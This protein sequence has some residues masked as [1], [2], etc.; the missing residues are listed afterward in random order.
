[1]PRERKK[2]RSA[3]SVK[4]AEPRILGF[5]REHLILLAIFLFAVFVRIQ[6]DPNIPYHYDPGKNIVYARAALQSF[7]LF[8]Q[9]NPYFNLGEYF[10]YQVLFPYTVAFLNLLTGISLVDSTKWLVIL[11][12]SA[13]CLTVYYLSLELFHDETAALVSAFVIAASKIQLLAYMNYYP[14]ILAMMFMPL[15]F[16]FLIRYVRSGNARDLV[17]V[18]LLSS[19]IVLASY[20]AAFVYFLIVAVSLALWAVKDT[21]TIKTLL[22]VPAMTMALLTFFWLPIAWRLGSL[23]F[24]GIAK[25][26]LFTATSSPFTNEPWTLV[27]YLSVSGITVVTVIMGL[28]AL[29]LIRKIQWDFG[30]LLLAVWLTCVFF[31]MESY[32]VR[33]ILWVDR[34]AQFLDIAVLLLTG[35]LFSLFISKMNTEKTMNSPVGGY[36]LLLLLLLPLYG[37]VHVDTIYGK[38]GYP[39]DFAA[40]EYMK[41]LPPGT[42]VVAPPSVQSFWVSALSGAHVLGGE[43]AQMIYPMYRGDGDSNTIINSA[44]VERKMELI[45]KYG[46]NYVLIPYHT[47]VYMMWNAD[48]DQAGVDAFNN[49]KYFTVEKYFEDKYGSTV[50]LK[51][52]ENLTPRY[53][54]LETNGGVTVAGYLVS[55]IV[56]IGCLYLCTVKKIPQVLG[57]NLFG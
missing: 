10:D 29:W 47:P 17:L 55:I 27:N 51:V 49:T 16:L 4:D 11:A 8:P 38:W 37:A 32:L 23:N 57:K 22:L 30:K 6:A 33:P 26:G 25:W 18:A 52:R 50:L 34:Y 9:T 48:V 28:A 21:G 2:T 19:L 53:N 36:I 56:F 43:S 41:G 35:T 5:R 40:A 46:V 20:I 31:L 39:S 14:Q 12:G 24:F 3:Q 45:R 13:L 1:M 7:P 15:G 54:A 42:L 44:D